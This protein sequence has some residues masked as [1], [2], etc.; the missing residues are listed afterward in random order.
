MERSTISI[1]RRVLVL[2][3]VLMAAGLLAGCTHGGGFHG[4]GHPSIWG[5][6]GYGGCQ[7]DFQM[8]ADTA[9]AGDQDSQLESS[10]PGEVTNEPSSIND[11]PDRSGSDRVVVGSGPAEFLTAHGVAGVAK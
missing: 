7:Q 3:A 1:A 9:C 5:G 4:G 8:D 2:G 10:Y 11:S 6:G